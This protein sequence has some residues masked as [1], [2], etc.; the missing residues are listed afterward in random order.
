M[1]SAVEHGLQNRS[2]KN[3]ECANTLRR[4]HLVAG[5]REQVAANLLYVDRHLPCGLYSVGMKIDIDLS[6]D[7]CDFLDWLQHAG[8]VVRHHDRYQL[9]VLTEGAANVIGMNEAFPKCSPKW[10][11]MAS[12]TSGRTGVLALLSK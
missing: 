10:G 12:K 6:G 3:V 9:G 4:V 7:F 8:F 1:A 11:R 5:D 2:F